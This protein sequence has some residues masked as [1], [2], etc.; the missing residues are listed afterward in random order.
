MRSPATPG[1]S[2][3]PPRRLCWITTWRSWPASLARCPGP[4]RW[5]RPAKAARSPPRTRRFWAAARRTHGDAGG[6]RALVEV[7]LLHRHLPHSD[8]VTGLSA[9]VAVGAVTADVVAVEAR[10]VADQRNNAPV[11]HPDARPDATGPGKNGPSV[12]GRVVSL[13]KR[14]LSDRS[15]D[16]LGDRSGAAAPGAGRG[17]AGAGLPPESRPVPSVAHYDE[18]LRR[19]PAP[20]P[21]GSGAPDATGSSTGRVS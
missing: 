4:P 21:N 15:G 8:I 16:R 20:R 19:R 6:T 13:T 14:R 10:K 3:G 2:G 18:L 9:A 12:A 5:S 17:P 7:L 11:T 1:Q